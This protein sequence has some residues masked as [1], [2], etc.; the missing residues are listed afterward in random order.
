MYNIIK[1]R[2]RDF[3]EHYKNIVDT[4]LIQEPNEMKSGIKTLYS[5]G[6]KIYTESVRQLHEKFNQSHENDIGSI[7][8]NE[9]V[10]L[11]TTH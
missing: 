1:M 10:L 2:K 9:T 8:Q 6:R 5:A 4:N 11:C 7:F 3:L